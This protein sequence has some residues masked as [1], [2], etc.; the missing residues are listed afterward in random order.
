MST[1]LCLPP[2]PFA[3]SL[4]V[5]PRLDLVYVN[6]PKVACS[7]IKL[8]LQQAELADPAYSPATSVHDHEASPLLTYPEVQGQ[9]AAALAGR[10]V[11]SFVR[12]PYTR[13][14][15]VYLNKIV[16][17]QKQGKFRRTAGFAPEDC[18]PFADFVH[19]VCAQDPL[20][21][22]P[23]WRLQA[24][25]LSVDQIRFDMLGRL[26]TFATDWARLASTR[27]LPAKPSFAG[28]RT[29]SGP[30]AELTFDAAMIRAVAAAYGPDFE[31]FGYDPATPP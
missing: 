10:F 19:A 8:T 15:S 16:Q 11:F 7:S 26:E 17:P 18:P 21:Q 2:Q 20:Q 5:S 24:L 6:N 13:L 28:K 3:R 4:H 9:E 12:N 29:G 27:D 14:R 30:Q 23:H 25:N 22:N 1:A 31:H